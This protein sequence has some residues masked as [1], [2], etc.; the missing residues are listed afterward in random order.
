MSDNLRRLAGYAGIL[1]ALTVI[2]LSFALTLND[3]L[4]RQ[5]LP[6]WPYQAETVSTPAATRGRRPPK[7]PARVQ[8]SWTRRC[9]RTPAA[10]GRTPPAR[11]SP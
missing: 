1:A 3:L 2:Y 4:G 5:V 8:R 10:L 7:P 11:T 9:T 6:I